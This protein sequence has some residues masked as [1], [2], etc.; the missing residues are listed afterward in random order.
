MRVQEALVYLGVLWRETSRTSVAARVGVTAA[1][2]YRLD[3]D[4]LQK[5]DGT[6]RP[7]LFLELSF[8]YGF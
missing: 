8:G 4:P 6:L 5:V 3:D 1:G 2:D 7:E